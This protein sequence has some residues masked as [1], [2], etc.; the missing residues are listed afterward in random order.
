MSSS[1]GDTGRNIVISVSSNTD[2]FDALSAAT[3]LGFDNSLTDTGSITV[4]IDSGITVGG[5]PPVSTNS[6]Y[7]AFRSGA[8]GANVTLAVINNGT[9]TGSTPT[10]SSGGANGG[11]GGVGVAYSTVTGGS[12]THSF[13]NNGTI[14]GGKGGGGSGGRA[15]T[16]S[17][18]G[19][20]G[21]ECAAPTLTGPQGLAASSFAGTGN[22]GT[23]NVSTTSQDISLCSTG[24]FGYSPGQG[25]VGGDAINRAG[26]TVSITNNGTITGNIAV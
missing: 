13:I 17:P 11:T 10:P 16:V 2:Y 15:S 23:Y 8:L 14:N 20:G 7:G 9:I 21:T 22:P 18:D 3:A 12:A 4:T 1:S 25:G 26:R 6:N 5:V 19:D 24:D